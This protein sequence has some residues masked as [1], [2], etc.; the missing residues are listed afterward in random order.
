M[1]LQKLRGGIARLF[2]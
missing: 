1:K 2:L